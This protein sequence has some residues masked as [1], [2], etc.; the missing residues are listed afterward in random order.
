M[1]PVSLVI[2]RKD[3]SQFRQMYYL[4][5]IYKRVIHYNFTKRV[6]IKMPSSESTW[7]KKIVSGLGL[8]EITLYQFLFAITDIIL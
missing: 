4:V 7:G 6:L 2:V 8:N 1:A 3:Y 5:N